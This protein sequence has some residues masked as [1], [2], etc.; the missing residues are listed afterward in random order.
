M[1][2]SRMKGRVNRLFG[3]P[4]PDNELPEQPQPHQQQHHQLVD[5]PD[6]RQAL[7]VLMLAQR[8]ADEHVAAAHRQAEKI[9]ADA[10]ATAEQI[11]REA[12]A[13]SDDARRVADKA[14]ADARAKAEQVAREAQAHGEDARR[15]ADRLV[16][17]ARATAEQVANDARAHGERLQ[18]EAQ[19]RYD[20][21]VGRLP[22]QRAELQ[23][24][25][26]ALKQFDHNYR[27]RLKTFMQSQLDDLEGD[28][29]PTIEE[30]E[31]QGVAAAAAGH[32]RGIGN[33]T[34]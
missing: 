19:Q 30:I 1:T 21:A 20:E 7:Q 11:G 6:A 32:R 15:E 27:A 14:L 26:E 16:A 13:H 3:G 5:N 25:I 4:A 28:E 23:Q 33:G 12:Q 29:P 2:D 34:A 17:E 24:R 22:A 8:T 10:R 18:H 31:H 9:R